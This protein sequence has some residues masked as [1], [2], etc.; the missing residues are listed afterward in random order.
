MS[1]EAV[2]F[3]LLADCCDG[4]QAVVQVAPQAPPLLLPGCDKV[5]AGASQ[6]GGESHSVNG[7]LCLAGEVLK[8]APV[9]IGE[10]FS[11]CPRT[12]YETPDLLPLIHEQQGFG[13][14]RG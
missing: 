11:G 3:G 8:Q 14:C 2:A 4:P 13:F 10:H 1:D 9:S 12:Y 6:V 5:F 7:N